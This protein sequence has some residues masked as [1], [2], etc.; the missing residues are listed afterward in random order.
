MSFLKKLFKGLFF[1]AKTVLFINAA[2]NQ[3]YNQYDAY[4]I[5]AKIKANKH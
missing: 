4:T 5:Y 1:L 2:K 3:A